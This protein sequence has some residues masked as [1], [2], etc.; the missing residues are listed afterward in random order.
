[1]DN[2]IDFAYG[3][4]H[5]SFVG[6]VNVHMVAAEDDAHRSTVS[7]NCQTTQD[8]AW[9]QWMDNVYRRLP[10]ETPGTPSGP[11]PAEDEDEFTEMEQLY[12]PV[13]GGHL[14]WQDSLSTLS[15]WAA[16]NSQENISFLYEMSFLG[17]TQMFICIIQCR[18]TN[19][20]GI[21]GSSSVSQAHARHVACF[22]A[23]R[24][25]LQHGH[26]DYR[27]ILAPPPALLD[28]EE[29]LPPLSE[30]VRTR[31]YPRG[32]P[33][34][35]SKRPNTVTE[36]VKTILHSVVL[37]IHDVPQPHAPV[38]ILTRQPLPNLDD[39]VVH[40]EVPA[41]VSLRR[42]KHATVNTEQLDALAPLHST[43]R[44]KHYQQTIHS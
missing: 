9:C 35:W 5:M 6:S 43:D 13:T 28:I 3:L 23:C 34:F 44:P 24:T 7:H 37:T 36:G 21:Q 17:E 2:Q 27:Q 26:M 29:P 16:Q 11:H 1:M 41:R 22:E 20:H 15:R 32:K 18:A 38:L 8:V 39:F 10:P 19:I 33:H 42:N 12:D 31:Q 25:L 4:S 40:F 14:R 30:H